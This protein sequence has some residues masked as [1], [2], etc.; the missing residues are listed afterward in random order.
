MRDSGNAMRDS[1][2]GGDMSMEKKVVILAAL[3]WCAAL[4]VLTAKWVTGEA[5]AED[6]IVL[7]TTNGVT[8]TGVVDTV[9]V[10]GEVHR[11]IRWKTKEGDTV[12]QRVTGPTRLRTVE[13]DPIYVAGPTRVRSITTPGAT[14]THI[15]QG[16]TRTVT[17]PAETVT[18]TVHD[19]VTETVH[20]T[21]TETVHD[22]VTETVHDTVTETVTVTVPLA[23]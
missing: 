15:V 13:G 20:D 4:G 16:P 18:N 11:V 10:G 2:I 8:Q 21:V 22:T 5:K 19:T 9:T 23:P 7:R 1:M 14:S 3:V 12:T 17:L 6:A